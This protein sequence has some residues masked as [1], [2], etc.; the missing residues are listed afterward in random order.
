MHLLC[1]T[2]IGR[3][4]RRKATLPPHEQALNQ[5]L[6]LAKAESEPGIQSQMLTSS[7]APSLLDQEKLPA[8]LEHYESC[9]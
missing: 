8:A 7:L 1:L 5:K 4:Y 2:H 6:E 9:H 3:A